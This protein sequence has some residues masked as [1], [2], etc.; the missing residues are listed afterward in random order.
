MSNIWGAFQMLDT[1]VFCSAFFL[2]TVYSKAYLPSF[3]CDVE[4]NG[5]VLSVPLTP[6]ARAAW[7]LTFVGCDKSK[8]K[9]AFG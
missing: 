9:H 1:M 6:L 5:K 8:Q 7:A 4:L 3:L 2:T